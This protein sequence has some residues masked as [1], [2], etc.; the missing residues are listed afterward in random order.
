MVNTY[1]ALVLCNNASDAEQ[2]AEQMQ[3]QGFTATAVGTGVQVSRRF[4]VREE[5]PKLS[6]RWEVALMNAIT[7]EIGAEEM[8]R[9][10]VKATGK[11]YVLL[12]EADADDSIS[13][14]ERLEGLGDREAFANI[15]A[16]ERLQAKLI[17]GLDLDDKPSLQEAFQYRAA[18]D[19]VLS[20]AKKALIQK[21]SSE[22]GLQD[23]T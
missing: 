6:P 22:G 8:I 7:D 18:L 16:V 15:A 10:A 5:G 23:A 4:T 13:L 1:Y 19:V 21:L 2:T 12:D 17:D 14:N 20:I 11:P 9:D 3:T